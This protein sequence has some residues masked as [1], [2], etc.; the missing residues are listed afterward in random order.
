[1]DLF[2]R[3]WDLLDYF[4][5]VR[6]WTQLLRIADRLPPHS[7]FKHAVAD[8]DELQ[9][10]R[11]DRFKGRVPPARPPRLS[12]WTVFDDIMTTLNDGFSL[13]RHTIV[14]VNAEK[15]KRPPAWKPTRRPKS[16]ADRAESRRDM[17]TVMDIRRKVL[18]HK[19]KD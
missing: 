2:D 12:E 4:R 15:G 9:R 17:D 6:P 13:L 19:Y 3:G 1:M 10:W 5:G 8:D 7:R 16:A 14:S 11:E 18:P